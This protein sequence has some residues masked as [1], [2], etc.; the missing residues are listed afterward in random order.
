MEFIVAGVAGLAFALCLALSYT[1]I[2]RLI[3][4]N[5]GGGLKLRTARRKMGRAR[6]EWL[7]RQFNFVELNN[8]QQLYVNRNTY[9]NQVRV[10]RVLGRAL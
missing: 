9:L 1:A 3:A 2:E 10:Q 5:P 6:R 8:S 4:L 7:R